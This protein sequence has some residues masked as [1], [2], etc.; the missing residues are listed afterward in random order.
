M[1]RKRTELTDGKVLSFRV[2]L[3]ESKFLAQ[4]AQ[5]R[6]ISLTTLLHSTVFDTLSVSPT[7][8]PTTT[9]P[10]SSVDP[11]PELIL[12]PG[13]SPIDLPALPTSFPDPSDGNSSPATEW[14][15]LEQAQVAVNLMT[16]TLN[17]TNSDVEPS[18]H[19]DP[20]AATS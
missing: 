4:E 12:D 2:T 17:L 9:L 19:N 1:P 14:I 7:L 13:P 15:G 5:S 18:E 16:G 6:G 3:P 10:L 11:S 20:P 8:T